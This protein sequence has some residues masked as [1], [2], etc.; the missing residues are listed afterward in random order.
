M[1]LVLAI[2]G[3]TLFGMAILVGLGLNLVGLFGNWI[4]LL[5]VGAAAVLSGFGHFGGWTIAILFFLAVIGEVFETVASGVGAARFGGGKGAIIWAIG[6]SIAGGILGTPLIPIPILGT[7]LG[8]C[9]GAFGGAFTHEFMNRRERGIE[10]AVHVGAGAA[11]GKVTGILLKS[12]VGV[13]MLII[14]AFNL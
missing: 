2:I 6:G 11:V 3:W 9:L 4:I 13:L 8:A 10:S 7:I 12:G 1:S 5:A 14:A